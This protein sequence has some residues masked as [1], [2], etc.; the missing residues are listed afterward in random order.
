LASAL[1]ELCLLAYTPLPALTFRILHN[2]NCA[3]YV[4][5]ATAA[6]STPTV[7]CR[8][9]K[10]GAAATK[11]EEQQKQLKTVQLLQPHRNA[12]SEALQAPK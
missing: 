11:E 12:L 1:T 9:H 10:F 6:T 3:A 4:T 5:A 8:T 2:N 7:P